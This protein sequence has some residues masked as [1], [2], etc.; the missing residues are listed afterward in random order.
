MPVVSISLET[1]LSR[2]KTEIPRE[3]LAKK[4]R[5]LGCDVEGYATVK[6]FKCSSCDNIKEITETENPPVVCD[7][8]GYESGF[9]LI[10]FAGKERESHIE[11]KGCDGSKVFLEGA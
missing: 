10:D 11:S 5:Q 2:I 7:Q 1:L 8:C 6:R 4:L 3:D 9:S